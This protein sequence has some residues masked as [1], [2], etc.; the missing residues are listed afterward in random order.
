MNKVKAIILLLRPKHWVKNLF[1]Y[2]P[3][4]FA[5]QFLNIDAILEVL[6]AFFA[7]SFCASAIYIFNDYRDVES[8]RLHPKKRKRPI[9]SG[10]VSKNLALVLMLLLVLGSFSLGLLVKPKFAFVLSIYFFL[11][12]FYSSGGKKIGILDIFIVAFGFVLRVKAGGIVS[13]IPVSAW[14][15]VMIFLLA[16]LLTIAKRRDDVIIKDDSG[17]EM[18]QSIRNYNLELMNS[19]IVMVSGIIIVAYLIYTLSPEIIQRFGTHR[20]YYTSVFVIAGVMRYLQLVFV[21][22]DSGSPTGILYKDKFIQISI[23]LW[24]LSFVFFIYFPDFQL[25]N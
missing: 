22:N 25:F 20:I 10:D 6:P 4:F 8:D 14:L 12:L 7:F 13:E 17:K 2:I 5:G 3:L 18:R 1:L 21:E 24:I 19:M 23:A 16:L 11:N 15:N 9:A